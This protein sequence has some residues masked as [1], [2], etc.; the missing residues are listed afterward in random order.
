M[1]AS[2]VADLGM[3]AVP[4][5]VNVVSTE[6]FCGGGLCFGLVAYLS[7]LGRRVRRAGHPVRSAIH[8]LQIGRLVVGSV[9]TRESVKCP[10]YVPVEHTQ[11]K[12][13]APGPTQIRLASDEPPK[14]KPAERRV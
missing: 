12:L 9:T 5:V 3:T 7:P 10:V 14:H 8:K 13:Q 11:D 2:F 4:L 1:M 6:V